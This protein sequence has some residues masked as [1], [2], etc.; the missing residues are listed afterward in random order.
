MNGTGDQNSFPS[1]G[2][3]QSSGGEGHSSRDAGE[4]KRKRQTRI[5][6]IAAGAVLAVAVVAGAVITLGNP[7]GLPQKPIGESAQPAVAGPSEQP[8]LAVTS[9]A[10]KAK[11]VDPLS[12]RFYNDN[13]TFVATDDDGSYLG[14][15][16]LIDQSRVDPQKALG[17]Q[18]ASVFEMAENAINWFPSE[19]TVREI[20][21]KPKERLS[22]DDFI[23]VAKIHREIVFGVILQGKGHLYD[24]LDY[25]GNDTASSIG[26][27]IAAAEN[28]QVAGNYQ[29]YRLKLEFNAR[30]GQLIVTDNSEFNSVDDNSVRVLGTY[31]LHTTGSGSD[32]GSAAVGKQ[33]AKKNT[34]Q[35]NGAIGMEQLPKE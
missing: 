20:L 12:Y 15:Y 5:A 8:L 31:Q 2:P 6:I 9:G 23:A 19:K 4:L 34:V 22:I 11:T 18:E 33:G 28:S 24:G 14:Y 7:T 25:I 35:L 30:Y 13:G 16:E 26:Q 32:I 29:P 3:G 27:D 17:K 1:D 10:A 21:E